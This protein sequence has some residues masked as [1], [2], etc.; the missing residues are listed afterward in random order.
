MPTLARLLTDGVRVPLEM[1]DGD[2]SDHWTALA[3]GSHDGRSQPLWHRLSEAGRRTH[4]VGW[5]Y[6]SAATV[7]GV[8]VTPSFARTAEPTRDR[9][10]VVP[11]SA[12]APLAPYRVG[13]DELTTAQLLPF[14]PSLAGAPPAD[15]GAEVYRPLRVLAETLA[16]CTSL[17]A[18]AT[19][20]METSDWDAIVVHYDALARL[21]KQFGQFGPSSDVPTS[22]TLRERF[23]HVEPGGAR[24]HDMMLE[25]LLTL[26]GDGAAVVLVGIPRPSARPSSAAG[27]GSS[28]AGPGGFVCVCG[29]RLGPD[30]PLH[31][32]QVVP[33]VL[34]ALGFPDP[35]AAP[36]SRT[37][38][39]LSDSPAV[40][41]PGVRAAQF[42]R[43]RTALRRGKPE[44]AQPLLAALYEEG[45]DPAHGM[46]LVLC[47]LRLKRPTDARTTFD[48]LLAERARRLDEHE[49]RNAN[50]SNESPPP[51]LALLQAKVL[52]AEKAY[53]EAYESLKAAEAQ[54]PRT[55]LF[56]RRLG[57]VYLQLHAWPDA[58]RAFREAIAIAPRFPA[59]HR[60]LAVALIRRG[61]YEEAL[62]AASRAAALRSPF[63]AAHYHRAIAL[64]R[65]ERYE[66]AAEAAEVCVAQQPSFSRA[67]YLLT[68][69]Y[70]DHL[71]QPARAMQHLLADPDNA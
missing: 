48:R 59:G 58:E 38:P 53:R 43:A 11:A 36:P 54:A 64:K 47:H 6:G 70:R 15:A 62:E 28:A 18:A 33:M 69:L 32:A 67:R 1:G 14:V 25:R 8:E 45:R 63:P 56:Y 22:D 41:P 12:L 37:P 35:A 26:A 42:D 2:A 23:E 68:Q 5:P 24:F 44:D 65:L 55:A 19:W 49:G 3:T 20:L 50:L 52:Y 7:E 40:T 66:E 29:A 71:D 51:P 57:G 9:D 13:A 4:V 30:A 31:V 34:R 39:T 60:W 16:A 21:D 61:H 17:H 10:A 27:V 46:Q